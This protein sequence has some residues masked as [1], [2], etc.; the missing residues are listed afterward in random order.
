MTSL[1]ESGRRVRCGVIG[2]GW[3]ATYAHIP[4]LLSHPN[5]ELVAIQKRDGAEAERVARDFGIPRAVTSAE[6]ML[7]IDGLDAVV[8]SSAPHLHFVQAAAALR[9]GLHVLIEKPMTIA[10]GEARELVG[11]AK[12]AGKQLLISCPWHY[13]RHGQT[14]RNLIL[15]GALGEV[16]MASILMTNPVDH[17]IRGE[18]TNPTH[19]SP[20]LLPRPGT[21]SDPMVAGGGQIYTQVSHVAAYLTFLT[22]ARPARVFARFHNDGA[23]LDIYDT[24]SITLENGCLATVASTGATALGRRDCEVRVFGTRA[25]L[26]LELWAGSMGLVPLRGS[27][28]EMIYPPLAS[29]ETYPERAP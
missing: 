28:A 3:W 27:G 11:L 16:R 22:G 8:V 2:A 20:Y 9:K 6:E 1:V 4:A 5:A 29:E 17:L 26:F 21:Y 25:A 14:A 7:T 23:R 13:T 12:A 10:A 18:S 15:G 24:L 19:G